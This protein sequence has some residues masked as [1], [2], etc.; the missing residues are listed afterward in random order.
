M[1]HLRGSAR[2]EYQDPPFVKRAP[3][4]K[5]LVQ[6]LSTAKSTPPLSRQAPDPRLK[7]LIPDP[8]AA[9][10][11]GPR[12][13]TVFPSTTWSWFVQTSRGRG[14]GDPG[15]FP[16]PARQQA[17][18]RIAG[19]LCARPLPIWRRR[20]PSDPGG[21]HR[22]LHQQQ[23]LSRRMSVDELFDDTTRTLAVSS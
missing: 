12:A 1:D 15:G 16:A 11:N 8:E 7:H 14:L 21:D 2:A 22:L 19:W 5:E 6:M 23:L 13:I 20:L 3:P 10:Q 17:R 18:R 4:G 9:A